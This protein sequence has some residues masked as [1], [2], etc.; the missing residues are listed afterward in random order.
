M[1]SLGKR[2]F[3]IT[4]PETPWG[5]VKAWENTAWSDVLFDDQPLTSARIWETVYFM[6]HP[7]YG[8]Y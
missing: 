1:D 5:T 2:L 8:T 3:L 6:L 4:P 7:G